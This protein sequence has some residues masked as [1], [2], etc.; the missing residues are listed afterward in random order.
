MDE[1]LECCQ[2]KKNRPKMVQ[3]GSKKIAQSSKCLL[4]CLP[5]DHGDEE[6]ERTVGG[7][8]DGAE[9]GVRHAPQQQR[10]Q[11]QRRVPRHD[12][13][14]RASDGLNSTCSRV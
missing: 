10:Q 2:L 1:F 4:N 3:K 7:G 12:A 11:G 14:G 9:D 6:E 13:V 5:D 8:A